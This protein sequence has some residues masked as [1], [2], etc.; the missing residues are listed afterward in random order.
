MSPPGLLQKALRL[1]GRAPFLPIGARTRIVTR[2]HSP[3][4]G[5]GHEFEV[6]LRG[7]RYAG[8][9]DSYI[10]WRIYFFGSY[11]PYVID[12]LELLMRALPAGKRT[13]WDVGANSGQHTLM[14]AR[15]LDA[16]H[17]FEPF[18]PVRAQLERNVAM[19]L[20]DR[21]T[22][23][24]F[25]LGDTDGMRLFHAPDERNLGVGAFDGGFMGKGKSAAHELQIRTGD[26]VVAQG[27]APPPDLI[28]ID[29]EGL[30]PHVL[31]GLRETIA[32]RR[33]MVLLEYPALA[34]RTYGPPLSFMPENYVH[35]AVSNRTRGPRL[36]PAS[37]GEQNW[38]SALIPQ[39]L[40]A[41]VEAL[42]FY[43][44]RV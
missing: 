6:K 40:S 33:P 38:D 29:V 8:A 5:E 25:G 44:Q 18:A 43:P 35:Y 9:L 15:R 10:D 17:A 28:K 42:A 37:E 19:N 34:Y 24:P 26:S 16:V 11:E 4:T 32:R 22:V 13:A 27:L 3:L 7:M 41:T 21:V 12:T 1:I 23:H 2:L 14:M 39:E 36:L 30:E 20:P 31:K